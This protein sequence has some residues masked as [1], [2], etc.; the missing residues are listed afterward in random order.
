[1]SV[2]RLHIGLARVQHVQG[3]WVAALK[4]WER[5]L[6]VYDNYAAAQGFGT[7]VVYASIAYIK[8]RLGDADGS[9]RYAAKA[10]ELFKITGRKHWFTCL[11]TEWLDQV[12]PAL[13]QSDDGC[14]SEH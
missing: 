11:G 3:N 7:V 9:A 8:D 2:C 1:M 13:T 4:H 5:A 12:M 6:R 14:A 10:Q